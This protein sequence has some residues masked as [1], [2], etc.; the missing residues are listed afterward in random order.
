MTIGEVIKV[1]FEYQVKNKNI[2]K[3]N[4]RKKMELGKTTSL[5]KYY[6][7]KDMKISTLIKLSEA[8]EIEATKLFNFYYDKR[9]K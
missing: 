5:A 8:M 6:S 9:N 4:F 3:K 1:F 2:N 7:R